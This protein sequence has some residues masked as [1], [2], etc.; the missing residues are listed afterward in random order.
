[1]KKLRRY[2]VG[3]FHDP[4]QK[5]K[6][7]QW[8]SYLRDYSTS[9]TLFHKEYEIFAMNGKEAKKLAIEQ[10]R[11]EPTVRKCIA[12]WD[13]GEIS[14]EHGGT[15]P[16]HYC[17]MEKELEKLRF[18][19]ELLRRGLH[20]ISGIA[21][22]RDGYKT[23]LSLGDLV[24]ELKQLADRTLNGENVFPALPL[25]KDIPQEEKA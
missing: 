11:N 5:R 24:D 12:C 16:C 4:S 25:N 8:T 2:I 17:G 23:A 7:N 18:E 1:M 3:V 19:K 9:W 15:V 21:Y 6:R 22:D 14:F 10:A 13:T 20:V